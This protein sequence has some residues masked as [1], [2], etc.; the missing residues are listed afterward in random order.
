MTSCTHFLII[1]RDAGHSKIEFIIL[2]RPDSILLAMAISPSLESN[3]TL[4][5]SFR[6]ILTGSSLFTVGAF[7]S[8]SESSS[9]LDELSE[10]EEEYLTKYL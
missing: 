3:S 2:S 8:S 1:S 7:S 4:P 10:S 9:L 5:I 6:Y